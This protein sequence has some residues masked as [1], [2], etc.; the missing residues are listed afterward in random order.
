MSVV[1][2]VGT[3][4]LTLEVEG[5]LPRR[6]ALPFTQG[7]TLDADGELARVGLLVFRMRGMHA[8]GTPGP[9]LSYGEALWR[10]GI[11]SDGVPAWFAA[12]CD[13][14]HPLVRALGRTFIRYP[15]CTARF[16]LVDEGDACRFHVDAAHGALDVHAVTSDDEPPVIGPR[17]LLSRAGGRLYEIPWREDPA[18]MRRVARLEWRASSLVRAAFGADVSWSSEAHV[19]RGRTHRCGIA[20]RAAR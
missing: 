18:P 3:E 2:L 8:R 14:D 11:V 13:L 16:D 5:R 4:E 6:H 9:T 7:L 17:R 1:E 12:R 15:V 10:I 20:R 19:L